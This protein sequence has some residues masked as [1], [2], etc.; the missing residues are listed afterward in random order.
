[1]KGKAR[2]GVIYRMDELS[3]ETHSQ[4][5]F[6]H[7]QK[8]IRNHTNRRLVPVGDSWTVFRRS[9]SCG[10]LRHN[11]TVKLE[12]NLAG[13]TK[14]KKRPRLSSR[15]RSLS[16]LGKYI[17]MPLIPPI[18]RHC[19]DALSPQEALK[20]S[21]TCQLSLQSRLRSAARA[22]YLSGRK[23]AF[24]VLVLSVCALKPKF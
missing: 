4:C 10:N 19:G 24:P 2:R 21:L 8:K 5:L 23:P 22:S 15:G 12:D 17:P 16:C 18:R 11:L 6:H 1:M 14:Q 20:P 9:I 7:D 13:D 3:M